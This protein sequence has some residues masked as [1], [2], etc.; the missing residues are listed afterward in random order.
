MLL[1]ML[2]VHSVGDQR[3]EAQ[4]VAEAVADKLSPEASRCAMLPHMFI[5]ART[6]L[7]L[8]RSA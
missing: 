7:D 6:L 5:P 2:Q 1:C 8:R 4:V 3:A